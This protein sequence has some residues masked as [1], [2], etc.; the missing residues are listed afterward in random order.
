[1]RTGLVMNENIMVI[2]F[3]LSAFSV[4]FI[5]IDLRNT[6][7]HPII[8]WAFFILALFT[9]PFALLFYVIGCREPLKQMH[10]T[11]VAVRWRQVLGST[12]HCAAGDGIGIIVG[13][14][15]ATQWHFP[16]W[17][18][19]VF[20]YILGFGFGWGIFQAFAMRE[21]AGGSY[22]RSLRQTFLPELLSMNLLMT[23]MVVTNRLLMPVIAGS[24]NTL[25]VGF[26]FVMS[27]ALIVGFT[28]AYP[29]NWWLVST[30]LKHGMITVRTASQSLQVVKV[31][32]EHSPAHGQ[33]MS[34][35]EGITPM[36]GP[37]IT[38]KAIMTIISIAFFALGLALTGGLSP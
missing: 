18:D 35:F 1:M 17:G 3:V 4:F 15:L 2:W 29:I 10:E 20:E 6:P 12:M 23:G 34:G 36:V 27:M 24:T 7:A 5:V 8:K 32:S 38:W 33:P 11:F 28:F 30:G 14:V 26:W 37:S 21:M 22:L 9:G 19:L 25:S 16:A 31:A 13:T